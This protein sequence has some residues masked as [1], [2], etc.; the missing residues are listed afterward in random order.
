MAVLPIMGAIMKRGTGIDWVDQLFGIASVETMQSQFATA[1]AD[2]NVGAILLQVDSPGGEVH[3]VFDLADMIFAGRSQ[4][5][6]WAVADEWAYSAGYLLASA[7]ERVVMPRAAGVGSIGVIAVRADVTKL[8]DALGV[9]YHVVTSGER[10][11]DGNPHIA[12]SNVELTA[13]QVE[14]DRMASLFFAMPAATRQ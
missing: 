6:V 13:L 3:G 4:K 9:T 11:A 8:D 5:P 2:P 1:L 10:K 12:A 14:V 7:A